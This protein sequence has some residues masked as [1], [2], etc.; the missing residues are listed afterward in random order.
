MAT[1]NKYYLFDAGEAVEVDGKVVEVQATGIETG[2]LALLHAAGY[3]IEE[4]TGDAPIAK[5]NK[6]L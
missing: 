5:G 6:R 3:T 1:L 2:A 4:V